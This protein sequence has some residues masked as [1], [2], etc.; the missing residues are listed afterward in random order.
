MNKKNQ[1]SKKL[2]LKKFQVIK[3][4]NLKSIKGG[5]AAN[6]FNGDFTAS[7]PTIGQDK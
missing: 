6:D 2:T 1:N 3:L 7:K 5:D 4:N